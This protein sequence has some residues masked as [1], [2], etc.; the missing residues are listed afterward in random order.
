MLFSDTQRF[1]DFSQKLHMGVQ[2][3]DGP[4]LSSLNL[5]N[6]KDYF[7]LSGG[8]H[9]IPTTFSRKAGQNRAKTRNYPSVFI[10]LIRY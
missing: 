5:L 7:I 6:K 2:M 4:M 8:G 3:G 1:F 10:L 9:D